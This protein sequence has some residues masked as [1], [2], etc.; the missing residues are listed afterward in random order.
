MRRGRN[1]AKAEVE[2]KQT[3]VGQRPKRAGRRSGLDAV[4][5]QLRAQLAIINSVQ[6]ALTARLS[7]QEIYDAVGDKIREIFHNRD[8][9]IRIYE[10]RT[11]LVHYPYYYEHGRRIA[12]PSHPLAERGFLAHVLRTSEPLVISENTVHAYEQ[13]GSFLLPGTRMEKSAVFVPLMAGA[14]ARGSIVLQDMEREHA[15]SDSDVRLLQT[16]ANSMST[17]LENVRLFTELQEK[18]LALTKTHAQVTESLEQQTATAEVL[19]VIS[20]STFDLR[21]VLETLIEHATRLCG[22]YAGDISRVD[23]ELLRTVATYNI[24]RE[25]RDFLEQNPTPCAPGSAGGRAVLESRTI[26]FHDVL[27]DPTYTYP[28]KRL[29]GYRT[30]LGVPMLREGVPIGVF[31]LW[32]GEV[33]PFTDKQIELVSTFADQAVIAIENVRLLTEL[34]ARTSELTRSVDELTALGDVGRALS[35]TLDLEAVLQPIVSRA[36][37]LAG[38]DGCSIY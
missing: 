15:F 35:S 3:T 13:Y 34:Q 6:Q 26:H 29:G 11:N 37:E 7:L 22:A 12:V 16:L 4:V 25:H 28:G 1:P 30:L 10:P 18:N 20:R 21:P 36:N 24:S 23:G 17:A 31:T 32:R 38:T 8:V 19:K 14:E 27:A 5:A 33:R 9:E 2:G